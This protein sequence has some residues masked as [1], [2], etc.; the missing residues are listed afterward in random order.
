VGGIDLKLKQDDLVVLAYIQ[1]ETSVVPKALRW[2]T[3]HGWEARQGLLDLQG[4]SELSF[5]SR[6]CRRIHRPDDV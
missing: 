5:Q 1:D 3:T 4:P 2:T 6:K